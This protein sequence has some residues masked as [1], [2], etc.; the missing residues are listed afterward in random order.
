MS[1]SQVAQDKL[2]KSHMASFYR[3]GFRCFS[4]PN[5]FRMYVKEEILTDMPS[6]DLVEA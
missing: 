1:P 5:D 4:S 3:I 6:E 2:T